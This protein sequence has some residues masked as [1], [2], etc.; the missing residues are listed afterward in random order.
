MSP[1]WSFKDE[2]FE[3][4]SAAFDNPDF[5]NVVIHSYRHRYG[6]VPGDP[7]YAEVEARLAERPDITVPTIVLLGADD[8][9]DPPSADDK[10]AIHFKGAYS[11]R[12]LSGVGHNVPQEGPT[13]F[14]AAVRDLVPV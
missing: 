6:V 10:D 7:A 13:I 3:R 14:A 8:G 2:T 12:I 9:V 5:V 1:S 11:R 4:S